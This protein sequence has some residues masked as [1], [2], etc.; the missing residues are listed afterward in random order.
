[1]CLSKVYTVKNGKEKLVSESVCNVIFNQNEITLY[2]IIG[3]MT[4][5]HGTIQSVDL[6]KNIILIQDDSVD[7]NSTDKKGE[8]KK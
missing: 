5:V 2:D 3:Q 7:E 1:M 6:L 4:T 8:N